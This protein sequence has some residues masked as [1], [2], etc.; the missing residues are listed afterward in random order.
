M[1]GIIVGALIIV[2]FGGYFV[3]KRWWRQEPYREPSMTSR[4]WIAGLFTLSAALN[5]LPEPRT[6]WLNILLS[7]IAVWAWSDVV[8][9]WYRL[10]HRGNSAH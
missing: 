7:G 1:A 8:L 2:T 6:L 9:T 10:R 4:L 5:M 3:Y